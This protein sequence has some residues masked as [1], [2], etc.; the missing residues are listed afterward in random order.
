[1][2]ALDTCSAPV[3]PPHTSYATCEQNVPLQTPRLCMRFV[4]P[5]AQRPTLDEA[6]RSTHARLGGQLPRA[7]R[8]RCPVKRLQRPAYPIWAQVHQNRLAG[9]LLRPEVV[10]S[11]RMICVLA[12]AVDDAPGGR[13]VYSRRPMM[14]AMLTGGPCVTATSRSCAFPLPEVRQRNKPTNTLARARPL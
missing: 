4:M 2:S 12:A 9:L 11:L 1:M 13:L 7:G 8:L 3:S 6:I 14:D 10:A 5:S